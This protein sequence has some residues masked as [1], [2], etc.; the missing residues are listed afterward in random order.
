MIISDS[1]AAALIFLKIQK[2]CEVKKIEGYISD[3]SVPD[4]VYILRKEL[5]PSDL[6]NAAEMCCND[7]TYEIEHKNSCHCR[8][9]DD[10]RFLLLFPLNSCRWF[11]SYIIYNSV[12]I[13]NFIN[14]S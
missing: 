1:L 10:S 11:C 5:K 9:A 12:D 13:F 4:I 2:L 7:Y 8:R 3:L 6:K 14:N